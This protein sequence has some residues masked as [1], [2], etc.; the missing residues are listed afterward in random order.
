MNIEFIKSRHKVLIYTLK[1]GT[2]SSYY[3]N[4]ILN[5][6]LLPDRLSFMLYKGA[7]R[8][9]LA[10]YEINGS[11]KKAEDGIYKEL[12]KGIIHTKIIQTASFPMFI[13]WGEIDERFKVYDLLILYSPD[14]CKTIQIHLFKG[15][16]KPEYLDSVCKYLLGF[17]NGKN[18]DSNIKKGDDHEL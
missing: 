1:E 15:L 8:G 4:G 10:K 5:K 9:M 16:A 7:K 6:E 18:V 17:I 3:L 11:Y 13:G 2:K 14:H 12:N